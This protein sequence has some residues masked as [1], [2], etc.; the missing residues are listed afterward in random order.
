MEGNGPRDEPKRR[1]ETKRQRASLL[2]KERALRREH[3]NEIGRL[4]M[5]IVTLQETIRRSNRFEELATSDQVQLVRDRSLRAC[6]DTTELQRAVQ[7][8]Q[9]LADN[10]A[11][12]AAAP[13]SRRIPAAVRREVWRRD[14]G[15]CAECGSR[16]RL[17]FDHIH[18]VSK[19]GSNTARN[20]ELLCEGCNRRKSATI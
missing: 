5:M 10:L 3:E 1:K 19:G 6:W 17:E 11:R 2:R 18:P 14:Q 13:N 20:V 8:L 16:E 7:E 15:R 9:L 12:P 4:Q